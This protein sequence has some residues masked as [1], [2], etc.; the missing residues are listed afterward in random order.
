MKFAVFGYD[1]AVGAVESLLSK[2]HQLTHV[3]SFAPESPFLMHD[4]LQQLAARVG[5]EFS[6][7]K[8]N[9]MA[10]EAAKNAGVDCFLCMGYP[11]KI[12]VL[13]NTYML[14]I[15]PTLLPQGAGMMPLPYLVLQYPHYFGITV[16]KLAEKF[17]AGD[18]LYQA[19]ISGK[20]AAKPRQNGGNTAVENG[21]NRQHA[22]VHVLAAQFALA[23]QDILPEIFIRLTKLWEEATPQNMENA[24]WLPPIDAAMNRLDLTGHV[25]DIQAKLRAFGNYGVQAQVEEHTLVVYQASVWEE[26]HGHAAGTVV[27]HLAQ[28]IVVAVVDGFVSLNRYSVLT[29]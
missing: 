1:F 2:G 27:A 5:A 29:S 24:H 28:E 7:E 6:V 14:N 11:H 8:A 22:D 25:A 21:K 12:P 16:H 19:A 18:V 13:T 26:A 10:L 20:M 23:A 9:L 17:D 4:R 3:F 15:H